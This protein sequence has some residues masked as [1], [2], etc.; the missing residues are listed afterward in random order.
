MGVGGGQDEAGS[1]RI[2][3][4]SRRSARRARQDDGS[5]PQAGGCDGCLVVGGHEKETSQTKTK[6]GTADQGSVRWDLL[7]TMVIHDCHTNGW[8]AH[9]E[10]PAEGMESSMVARLWREGPRSTRGEG[11]C[12]RVSIV[13]SWGVYKAPRDG[14]SS[15]RGGSTEEAS[16]PF[17]S[18]HMCFLRQTVAPPAA[19]NG[20]QNGGSQHR[21]RGGWGDRMGRVR[22]CGDG[23]GQQIKR[24]HPIRGPSH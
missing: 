8:A 15:R 1:R 19:Q 9:F 11:G 2:R 7:L 23:H 18:L 17:A 6:K 3:T 16:W 14:A 21:E 10:M 20:T 22:G 4:R 13:T 5:G 24:C 12:D